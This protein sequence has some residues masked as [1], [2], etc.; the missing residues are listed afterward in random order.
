[1]RRAETFLHIFVAG[2]EIVRLNVV[3]AH[4]HG[5][6]IGRPEPGAH[7]GCLAGSA[8]DLQRGREGLPH[9]L[10]AQPEA[11]GH[12][13][14]KGEAGRTLATR[15]IEPATLRIGALA[16]EKA[17]SGQLNEFVRIPDRPDR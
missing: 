14:R 6:R 12:T 4:I 11:A 9:V 10:D 7:F 1:M 5:L 3:M 2:I 17:V 15:G 13:A 8:V 16:D